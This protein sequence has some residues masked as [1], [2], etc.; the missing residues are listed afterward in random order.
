MNEQHH[1]QEN[2]SINQSK[3]IYISSLVAVESE[4]LYD[5]NEAVATVGLNCF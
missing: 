4:A 2:Q 5:D 1:F 3:H